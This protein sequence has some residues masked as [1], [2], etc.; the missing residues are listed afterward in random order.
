LGDAGDGDD[1]DGSSLTN[2][3]DPRRGIRGAVAGVELAGD[4]A[5]VAKLVPGW[6][7]QNHMTYL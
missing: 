7:N 3:V 5:G 1:G 4:G 2:T 6:T